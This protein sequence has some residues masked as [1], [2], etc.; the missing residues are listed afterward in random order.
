MPTLNVVKLQRGNMLKNRPILHSRA[1]YLHKV[2][3]LNFDEFIVVLEIVCLGKSIE[4][5][6]PT[7]CGISRYKSRCLS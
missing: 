6:F 4:L 3:Y 1:S 5:Y 7:A 2:V